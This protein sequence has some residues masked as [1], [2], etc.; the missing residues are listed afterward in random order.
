MTNTTGAAFEIFDSNMLGFLV[1]QHLAGL[2][3]STKR[4]RHAKR[5]NKSISLSQKKNQ[6]NHLLVF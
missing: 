2:T 5:K 6:N 1:G 4:Q 3:F